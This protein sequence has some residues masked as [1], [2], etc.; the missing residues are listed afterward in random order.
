MN[1]ALLEDGNVYTFS[2]GGTYS[3]HVC[4]TETCVKTAAALLSSIDNNVDPCEDFYEYACGN[5]IKANPIPDGKSMWGTFVQL[6]QRNQL[7]LK[8]VLGGYNVLGI[9]SLELICEKSESLFNCKK[10]FPLLQ[11][12]ETFIA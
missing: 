6:E 11:F 9:R 1:K 4:L 2:D 10:L 12:L 7:V 8:T 3:P 5:W